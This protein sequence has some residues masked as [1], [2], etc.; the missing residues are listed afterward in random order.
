MFVVYHKET[1]KFLR[2]LR[3]GYWQDARFETE[4][5]AKACLT[6]QSKKDPKF[7]G[8]EYAIADSKT[9]HEKIEKHETKKNMMSGKEFT[10][11]VNTP[12]YC[13]PSCES[14]WSM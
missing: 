9:F 8:E 14:Y 2:I 6:R 11:P 12:S 13:D 4:S 7:N 1:T 5:A 10:Q 3:N